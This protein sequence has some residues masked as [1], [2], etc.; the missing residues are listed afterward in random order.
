MSP[1]PPAHDPAMGPEGPYLICGLGNPGPK[2][3]KNRHNAGFQCLD[4]LARKWS[5]TFNRMR[6][7]AHTAA[8]QVATAQVILAKP[9]TYMNSSGEAVA[10]LL[11][12]YKLPPTRLLVVYDDLG[13]PLGKI[14]FRPGGSA[15]GHKGMLSIIRQLGRDDFLRLR[16]GIGRP[17][18]GEPYEYVLNDFSADQE[19]AMREAWERG[20]AAIECFLQEGAQAAMNQ[21]NG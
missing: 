2:Y 15:G 19:I 3:A 21:F 10:P 13:L 11:H 17:E 12:W 6:F 9:L 16:L 7:K 14:R 5:L 1:T 4:L 18:H 20:V 8:G